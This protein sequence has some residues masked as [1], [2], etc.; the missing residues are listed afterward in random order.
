M[1]H[2]SPLASPG[3]SLCS[4]GKPSPSPARSPSPGSP[5]LPFPP[6]RA[7]LPRAD[8]QVPKTPVPFFPPLPRPAPPGAPRPQSELRRGKPAGGQGCSS[9]GFSPGPSCSRGCLEILE[10]LLERPRAPQA[11]RR[12]PPAGRAR[13]RARRP[14]RGVGAGA[15]PALSPSRGRVARGLSLGPSRLSSGRTPPRPACR[16]RWLSPGP[17]AP[18]PR[19]AHAG[20]GGLP[21]GGAEPPCACAEDAGL[22]G[23]RPGRSPVPARGCLGDA[24]RRGRERAS[25]GNFPDGVAGPA[26]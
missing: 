13:E 15:P 18:A 25:R 3:L 9:P 4:H 10:R 5:R 11:G 1:A 14:G 19:G 21:G 26:A 7:T 6:K 2:P 16:P 17:P 8:P 23:T 20:R 24:C 22:A 12:A